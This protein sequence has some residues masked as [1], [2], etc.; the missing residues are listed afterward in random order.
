MSSVVRTES[1]VIPDGK[2]TPARCFRVGPI[3]VRIKRNE[4][5]YEPSSDAL[6]ARTERLCEKQAL[7]SVFIGGLSGVATD[8]SHATRCATKTA[9]NEPT[10]I[11]MASAT[12]PATRVNVSPI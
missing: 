7:N 9:T 1:L 2:A 4:P 11:A 10:G 6:C 5:R 3:D 8:L 12:T